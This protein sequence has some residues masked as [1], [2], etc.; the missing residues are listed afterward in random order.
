M[1]GH[2]SG[3]T[4]KETCSFHRCIYKTH[5]HMCAHRHIHTCTQTYTR[6]YRRS[7]HINTW[8]HMHTQAC[9]IHRYTQ[10]HTYTH[11][12]THTCAH[13]HTH[14]RLPSRSGSLPFH[15]DTPGGFSPLLPPPPAV[16][17]ATPLVTV[18]SPAADNRRPVGTAWPMALPW[19]AVLLTLICCSMTTDHGRK[20]R[21]ENGPVRCA[22]VPAAVLLFS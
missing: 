1:C 3:Y 5:T 16:P 11:M 9:G 22:G 6:T 20:S 21:R 12:H 13:M 17:A 18:S 7:E 15:Q 4:Y 10:V 2:M 19:L 8:M 14:G